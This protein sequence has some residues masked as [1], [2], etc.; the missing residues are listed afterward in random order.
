MGIQIYDQVSILRSWSKAKLHHAILLGFGLKEMKITLNIMKVD[1]HSY[2]PNAHLNLWSSFN[3]NKFVNSETLSCGFAK[4]GITGGENSSKRPERLSVR[5][6]IKRASKSMIKFRFEKLVRSETLSFIFGRV[7][8]EGVKIAR[9]SAKVIVHI[10]IWNGHPNLWSNFN[11]ENLVKCETPSF[12]FAN[13]G[14]KGGENG[15]WEIGNKCN[16]L[17]LGFTKFS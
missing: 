1:V 9:T 4:I 10:F 14:L 3:F 12:N 16:L 8:L 11:S 15:F 2:L 5:L 6:S 7:G 13:V 17:G